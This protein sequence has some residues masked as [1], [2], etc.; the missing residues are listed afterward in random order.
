MAT[1][2]TLYERDTKKPLGF[3]PKL[4]E[5]VIKTLGNEN[6][7][8]LEGIHKEDPPELIK[9]IYGLD[10][11]KRTLVIQESYPEKNPHESKIKR[12]YGN[13]AYQDG[14]DIDALYLYTQAVI[15]APC[16]PDTHLGKDL[17]IAL[18]NRSAVLFSL[19]AFYLA[20]DD[21]KLALESGYPKELRYKLLERRLKILMFYKQMSDAQLTCKEL[22]KS[23]DD[24][25]LE[26]GKKLKLQK[27]AQQTLNAFNKMPS[28]YNDLSVGEFICVEKP[29]VSRILPEYVGS[30]CAH[31]FKSMKAPLP[32]PVSTHFM[33]CS[34]KCRQVA[35]ET[36]HPYEAKIS[37]FLI[38]SGMSIVC[39]LA[40][41]C[42]T[43]KP[44]KYFLENKDKFSNHNEQSG[45]SKD[46]VTKYLSDDYGNLFNLVTHHD[47]RKIGDI[48]HRAMFAIMMLRCLKKFGYFGP[49]RTNINPDHDELSEDELFI[50]TILNHFLEVLQFNAH[51]V[52]QFEMITKNR[53]EGATSNFIGAG[54]Y[55]T[56]AMFNHSCDPSIVRFYV[57]D[58]VCV[59]AIKNLRKGDEVCENYGPIFF[60]SKKEERQTQLTTQY[61]FE[62]QCVACQEDWPM[63][64]EMTDETLNFR[65]QG[66]NDKVI[67]HTTSTNPMLRCACGT[68]VPMLKVLKK[69]G[70][71]DL[72]SAK[73]KEAMETGDL[74]KAQNLYCDF[75]TT[76]D[77]YLVPPYQDYYKIQQSI[78]KCIWMR[79]GNRIVRSKVRK[80]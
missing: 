70:E 4:Y 40:Y 63:M 35:L 19:K 10:S 41:R 31:C 59:Q 21:I 54:V 6:F 33:F 77:K 48:F 69:L 15:A 24:A 50:G 37:D 30:N 45:I 52:A 34:Y 5:S 22:I 8:F 36:Y 73:A 58:A 16:D 65:C 13:K 44:L 11:F 14:K 46:R 75:L 51:E 20:L 28:V 66:C 56:L 39:Y 2:K 27:E 64:H 76:L 29:V 72:I 42:V 12:D 55:P 79:F 78:W 47:E 61:W 17:A 26:A 68:P 23:L 62:C 67:F 74:E 25:K 60:H 71:T 80:P 32:C 7:E 3:F 18:A 57:E 53:E 38:A 1:G 49:D 43:K 9:F